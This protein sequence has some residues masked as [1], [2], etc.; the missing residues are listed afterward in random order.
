[1]RNHFSDFHPSCILIYFLTLITVTVVFDH[2]AVTV[3]G[4]FCALIFS[5]YVSGVKTAVKQF[6][7]SISMTAIFALVS[8]LLS[9]RGD[10]PVLYINDR[11]VTLESILYGMYAGLLIAVMILWFGIWHKTL[12]NDK[13]IFLFGRKFPQSSLLIR[14]VTGFIP[15]FKKKLSEITMVQ[16][17]LGVCAS[18]GTLK[19][20]LKNSASVMSVLV[21]V[22]LEDT[23]ETADSM[24]ARGYSLKNKSTRGFYT[25]RTCDFA[26]LLITAA[27]L[28]YYIVM[29][30][31]HT[32]DFSFYPVIEIYAISY[33]Q[34]T[35]FGLSAVFYSIPIAICVLEDIH[36]RLLQSK[37]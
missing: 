5:A 4:F 22:T 28:V 3:T 10:T 35:L 21:S 1:M 23:M 6:L 13:F 8:S 26:M 24:T 31:Q 9:H 2:P 34:I 17:T 12:G 11:P 37:I 25:F 33:R 29:Y 14:M 36:W 19:E 30:T 18:D 15:Y 20:R 7:T 27:F 32:A 16:R